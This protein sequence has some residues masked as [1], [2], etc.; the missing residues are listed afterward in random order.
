MSRFLW[1]TSGAYRA[2]VRVTARSKLAMGV[3]VVVSCV[4]VP[5]GATY[6][7]MGATNPDG[8]EDARAREVLAGRG[9]SGRRESLDS[10]MLRERNRQN[11]MDMLRDANDGGANM[12][13][14]W[15]KALGKRT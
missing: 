14:R 8:A 3:F 1:E 7:V 6:A 12:D 11:L 2:L 15:K 10:R 5:L 13:A 9:M 4:A